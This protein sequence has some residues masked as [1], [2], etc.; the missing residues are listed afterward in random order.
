MSGNGRVRLSQL[1][2]PRCVWHLQ[3]EAEAA[4]QSSQDLARDLQRA[5]A[6]CSALQE[7][8]SEQQARRQQPQH[9][10]GGT[11]QAQV[12]EPA[13]VPFFIKFPRTA[14]CGPTSRNGSVP[15]TAC[16]HLQW[17]CLGAVVEGE[18]QGS[19]DDPLWDPE[20]AQQWG[21]TVSHMCAA[22][23]WGLTDHESLMLQ[24]HARGSVVSAS[25]AA[26][27]IPARSLLLQRSEGAAATSV[28]DQGSPPGRRGRGGGAQGATAAREGDSREAL[29]PQRQPILAPASLTDSLGRVQ[30][31]I[32]TLR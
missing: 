11:S 2:S 8:L 18:S 25:S 7:R 10:A 31:D 29:T 6:R 17:Q 26:G 3:D 28:G 30:Q 24:S 19:W 9:R 32:I 21:P 5:E 16:S 13:F 1:Q 20:T 15:P 23:Q 4:E 22:S 27:I 12:R 14:C